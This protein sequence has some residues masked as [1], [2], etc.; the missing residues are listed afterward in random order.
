MVIVVITYL[1]VLTFKAVNTFSR[2]YNDQVADQ[3]PEIQDPKSLTLCGFTF[4]E[5]GRE[6]VASC[7]P[8]EGSMSVIYECL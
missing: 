6:Y 5:L 1:A 7:L 4:S 3:L 8:Y 2:H